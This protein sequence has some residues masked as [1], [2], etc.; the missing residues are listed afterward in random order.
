MEWRCSDCEFNGVITH[1][2]GSTADHSERPPQNVEVVATELPRN[3]IPTSLVGRW[4][5]EQMEVWDQEA[6]D[7]LGPGFIE[8]AKEHGSL[9]FVAVEGGLDCRYSED[10]GRPSVE[11]SWSGADDNDSACGRGWARLEPG[12]LLVGRIFIHCGDDSSFIAKPVAAPA[13][14]KRPLRRRSH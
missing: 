6:I 8:F 9:R 5:I 13:A 7:L 12:G 3:R 11:F 2:E 14:P 4:R 10:K 1:W